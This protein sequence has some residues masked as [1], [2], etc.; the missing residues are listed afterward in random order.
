MSAATG[1]T[2]PLPVIKM[3]STAIATL[4]A[5]A[6]MPSALAV[7]GCRHCTNFSFGAS[8]AVHL[9]Q[10]RVSGK[11]LNLHWGNPLHECGLLRSGRFRRMLC[12][13]ALGKSRQA[14]GSFLASPTADK[15]RLLFRMSAVRFASRIA[16]M[17][18]AGLPPAVSW[19][20]DPLPRS[21]LILDQSDRDSAWYARFLPRFPIDP[22][23]PIARAHFRLCGAPR[24][25]PLPKP[26]A[27]RSPARLSAEQV[28]RAADRRARGP[29]IVGAGIRAALACGAVARGARGFCR[30]RRGDRGSIEPSSRHDRNDLSTAVPQ[31]GDCRAGAGAESETNCAGRRPLGASSRPPPLPARH[32]RLRCPIRVH[33]PDR[34]ADDRDQKARGRAAGRYRDHTT[35]AVNFDGAGID[36]HSA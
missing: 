20:A 1:A 11:T 29:G 4:N 34:S 13:N 3:S 5:S 18:M 2:R 22:E 6:G 21:V 10:A 27:R 7:G 23:C 35:R 28:S 31:Y 30:G 32:P 19:A 26:T 9:A 14:V 17:L 36:L 33:R 24:P 16:I 15:I 8:G 12:C 25:Q